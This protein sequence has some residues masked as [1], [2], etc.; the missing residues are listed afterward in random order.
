[1]ALAAVAVADLV[2]GLVVM[3][4]GLFGKKIERVSFRER[5]VERAQL[6]ET[7]GDPGLDVKIPWWVIPAVVAVVF[8]GIYGFNTIRFRTIDVAATD[9]QALPFAKFLVEDG[10]STTE[11]KTT[12][13]GELKIPR[14]V[15]RLTVSDKRYKKQSWEGDEIS[16][17]LVVERSLFGKS[18]DYVLEKVD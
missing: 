13:D 16:D 14:G 6:A 5:R 1:M 12:V 15:D 2:A 9:G 4:V 17:E 8:L 11:L 7:E 18:L 3:V 10:F